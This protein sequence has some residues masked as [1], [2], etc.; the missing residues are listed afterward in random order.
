MRMFRVKQLGDKVPDDSLIARQLFALPAL[1]AHKI[2]RRSLVPD[3][4]VV[5]VVVVVVRR[6]HTARRRSLR[7]RVR[8][9]SRDESVRERARTSQLSLGR[10]AIVVY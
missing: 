7:E 9:L 4:V 2:R 10:R 5:V 6:D 1:S 8:E 3:V